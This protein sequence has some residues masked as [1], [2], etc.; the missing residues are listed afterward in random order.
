MLECNQTEILLIQ[1]RKLVSIM[2]HNFRLL[3]FTVAT[4]VLLVA[5]ADGTNENT[6]GIENPLEGVEITLADEAEESEPNA[7]LKTEASEDTDE[8]S[9]IAEE[10]EVAVE[11]A[12]QEAESTEEVQ[13]VIDPVTQLAFEEIIDA[14]GIDKEKHS[15]IFNQTED[16]IEIE[17]REKKDSGATPLVGKYRYHLDK[18]RV[19]SMDYLTGEFIPHEEPGE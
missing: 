14:I 1:I 17:V 4:S 15:F 5:C 18:D 6:S 3:F 12:A 7:L 19:L 8:L 2:L 11:D 16:Y 10:V 13:E 9:D